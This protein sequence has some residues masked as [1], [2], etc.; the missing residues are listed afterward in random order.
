MSKQ[1][2]AHLLHESALAAEQERQGKKRFDRIVEDVKK[3][4]AHKHKAEAGHD[5]LVCPSCGYKGPESEFE[6]DDDSDADGFRTD[7]V[8]SESGLNDPDNE[9]DRPAEFDNKVEALQAKYANRQLTAVDRILINR[10]FD[11]AED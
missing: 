11:P 4:L 10:G 7:P 1:T 6:P 2:L 5:D 3:H 8:T 9:G